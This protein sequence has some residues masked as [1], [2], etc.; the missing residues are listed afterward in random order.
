MSSSNVS[1]LISKLESKNRKE[2]DQA[3]ADLTSMGSEAIRP[4]VAALQQPRARVRA[5]TILVSLGAPALEWI[6]NLMRVEPCGSA[7][8]NAADQAFCGIVEAPTRK[9]ILTSRN[10]IYVYWIGAAAAGVI[11]VGIGLWAG[12]G[13]IISALMG[14]I[15]AYLIWAVLVSG[16]ELD[17]WWESLLAVLTAPFEFAGTVSEY[18]EMLKTREELKQKYN[19]PG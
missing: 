15:F 4:L 14:L 11:F 1:T 10:E 18:K 9:E 17:S 5:S 8:W 16:W 7:T 13:L 6:T 3:A 2:A 19:L 12:L